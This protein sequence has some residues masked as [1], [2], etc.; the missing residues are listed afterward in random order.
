MKK[1]LIMLLAAAMG[2]LMLTACGDYDNDNPGGTLST[3]PST[4]TGGLQSGLN[5]IGS[6]ISKG[7]DEFG[8]AVSGA[9]TS[10]TNDSGISSV[11]TEPTMPT[12]TS[13]SIG[14]DVSE[15][16]TNGADDNDT[17]P[18]V[19]DTDN[20]NGGNAESP[21]NGGDAKKAD[22]SKN[23]DSKSSNGN[24][25]SSKSSNSKSSGS[26]SSSK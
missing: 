14:T 4:P 7:L 24:S 8:G 20:P 6:D 21:E 15:D 17:I 11:P 1:Y 25:S 16:P 18:S 23:S 9:F 12:D 19:G 3:T 5:G 10:M 22:S 26:K 2:M 13:D